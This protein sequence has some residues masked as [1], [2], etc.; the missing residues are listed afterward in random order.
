MGPVVLSDPH[1]Y[2][3][4][5]MH[6]FPAQAG[7]LLA[8][9]WS[10]QVRALGSDKDYARDCLLLPCVNSNDPCGGCPA[11]TVDVPWFDFRP[12]AAWIRRSHG[13]NVVARRCKLF[14]IKG[15]SNLTWKDDWMHDKNLGTDKVSLQSFFPF[16]VSSRSYML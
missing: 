3:L 7:E 4:T 12:G 2:P 9:G 8:D 16:G 10:A 11:N 13:F 6:G 1:R 5:I 14:A 15:V